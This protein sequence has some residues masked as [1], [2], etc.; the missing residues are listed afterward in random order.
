M[1]ALGVSYTRLASALSNHCYSYEVVFHWQDALTPIHRGTVKPDMLEKY[2]HMA[3]NPE[4]WQLVKELR[5]EIVKVFQKKGA[6]SNQIGRTYPFMSAL[7]EPPANFLK[8]VKT[9]FDPHGL[10]NPGVLEMNS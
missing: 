7:T 6:A 1:M 3:P 4:A 5:S 9:Y 10:M 8:Q 2:G